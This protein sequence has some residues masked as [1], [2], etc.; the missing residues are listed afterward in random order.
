MRLLT[1]ILVFVQFLTAY[2]RAGTIQDALEAAKA[3][4]APYY[5]DI[6]LIPESV[7]SG[8]SQADTARKVMDTVN[9]KEFQEKVQKERERL[10]RELFS[11][12]PVEKPGTYTDARRI[13]TERVS[14]LASD[15]RVYLFISSS[16]PLSTLRNYARD[17]DRLQ[18]PN[19]CMVM[20]GF[21]GSIQDAS[22]TMEFWMRIRLKDLG[23]N[24][25]GCST[26]V[27]PI[28]IDP[29]LY[30]RF[31]PDSVP[32]LVYVRGVKPVDPDVSEGSPENVPTP[33]PSAWTMIY[34]DA[35][36]AYLFERIS[37]ATKSTTLA[38]IAGYLGR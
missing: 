11:V 26:Y 7:T 10:Q 12:G 6:Q 5:T 30:R 33:S 23:C 20:R 16:M 17:I 19:I 31:K 35:S 24:G 28:E 36:L 27:T 8:S 15:E 9:S 22:K 2:A 21:I 34:G 1:A 4:S 32:A 29:N 18:D 25:T 37:E 38:A 14:H 13:G 3:N